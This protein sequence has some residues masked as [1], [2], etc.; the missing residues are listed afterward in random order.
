MAEKRELTKAERIGRERR[1]LT[2]LF[3]AVE[4]RKKKTVLGLID[5]AAFL[6]VTLDEL[7][8]DLQENG[9]TEQFSQ[10]NQ[11]PYARERP[12]SRIYASMN[13]NYQKIIKQLT[14]L[15]PKDESGPKQEGDAFDAF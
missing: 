12:E 14:D 4:E 6:R 5:R 3:R 2:G 1:R 15:L 7:E 10:G 9:T 8:A 11:E 13:A